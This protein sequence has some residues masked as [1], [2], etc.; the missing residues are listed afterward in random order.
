MNDRSSR[1]PLL[2][3]TFQKLQMKKETTVLSTLV[4]AQNDASTSKVEGFCGKN[5][6]SNG[7]GTSCASGYSSNGGGTSGTSEELE[8]L[9]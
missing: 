6:S 9:I 2:T 7:G 4:N 8:I 3:L 5:Y 1:Y